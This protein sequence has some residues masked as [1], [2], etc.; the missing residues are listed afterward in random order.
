MEFIRLPK[1]QNILTKPLYEEVF[2]E[3]KGAF[4]D[5]YYDQAAPKSTIYAARDED[6]IHSMIH[7]N[8]YTL[9]WNGEL[10]EIPYIVAV[11]TQEKLRHRG[12][13]RT[14]L[15]QI[16]LDLEAEHV[17]FAFLMPIDEAIYQPF[18]FQRSWSWRW[19][20][21]VLGVKAPQEREKTPGVQEMQSAE[22][23]PDSLLERL[24]D[25]VNGELTCR[26]ELFT[27]RTVDYYR[28][29]ALEQK[30]SGGRL[31]IC[32]KDGQ[33]QAA[34]QTAREHYPSMMCRIM[35][36]GAYQKRLKGAGDRPF[37]KAFVCEVV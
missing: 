24:A 23:C 36:R 26:F 7:L 31:L 13:M 16:F 28:K 17:P 8:P 33:P 2:S 3:D 32:M 5:Y 19:E 9:C 29:L 12:L 30:A 22:D 4:S 15:E 20:E 35:D 27:L 21:D 11:A 25:H 1:E 37:D 14:L 10:I 18:G 34:V 6:G